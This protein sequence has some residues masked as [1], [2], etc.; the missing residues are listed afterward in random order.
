METGTLNTRSK[1]NDFEKKRLFK[2]AFALLDQAN[3]LLKK[4]DSD[5]K[6]E[7]S[8]KNRKAA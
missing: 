7:E 6:K 5:C 2:E 4:I 3:Y 8:E 1:M